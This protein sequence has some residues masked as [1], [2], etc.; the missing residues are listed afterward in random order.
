MLEG[1]LGLDPQSSDEPTKEQAQKSL[2][3]GILTWLKETSF[4]LITAI[5]LSVLLRTFIFQAF[6]VP[7]ESMVATLL[8]DDRIIASKLSYRFDEIHR[9]DIVVFADPGNWLPD[10]RPETG[11]KANVTKLFSW[12]GILPANSG[13]DLVKRVIGLPGDHVKCCTN[14]HIVVNGHV[15]KSEPYTRGASDQVE[16]DIVVP[17]GRLFVM[18]DNRQQS[19]DSRFHLNSRAGTIPIA[20]VV[21]QVVAIVWPLD[22]FGTMISPQELSKVPNREK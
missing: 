5:T 14:K 15:L 22:R 21:G 16:F 3:N 17:K 10:P 1:N 18:G 12:I 8:K 11:L 4:I 6:F 9:G 19:S 13:S 2:A 7:S 20:N